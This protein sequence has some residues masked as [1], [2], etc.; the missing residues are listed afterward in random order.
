MRGD[1]VVVVIVVQSSSAAADYAGQAQSAVPAS[2]GPPPRRNSR[3]RARVPARREAF[4][5]SVLVPFNEGQDAAALAKKITTSV[6]RKG[7]AGATIGKMKGTI[8]ADGAWKVVR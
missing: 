1:A 4:W 2:S 7:N 6:G 8:D 3:L 5:L